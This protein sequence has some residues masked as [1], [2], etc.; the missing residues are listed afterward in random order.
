MMTREDL[1][2]IEE[3]FNA[4]TKPF[5]DR[6]KDAYPFVLKQEH[7]ARVCRAMEMLCV[8]LGLDAPKTARACAAAMVHDMGRFPQFAV[9][10]TYSDAL[11]KNHAALGCREIVRSKILSHLPVTDRQLILRAVAL[12]NRPRLSGKYGRD[13]NLLARLL[14]DADKIDIFGVMKD[15]Y[16]NPDLSHGFITH[17]LN[18]DGK[19]PET[20]A[21]ELLE[22]RQNDLSYVNTL[23][24]MKVFQAGMVYDLNFPAAAAAVLDL[25]VIPV[26]LSGI[27]PSDLITGLEQALLD[28]LKFL[29]SSNH[30]KHGM[31]RK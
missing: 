25:E 11:S 8:S 16:L 30:G 9:F 4:Y 10:H 14:R 1:L 6:A 17:D 7:T 15:H 26:L 13:L 31:T 28:H 20:A 3:Q 2:K 21:R 23:N 18:D 24:S 5:V 19:I 22:T 12:H 27:P 29:A